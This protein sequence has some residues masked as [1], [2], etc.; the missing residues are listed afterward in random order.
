M[1]KDMIFHC[2]GGQV[3]TGKV[4]YKLS[5]SPVLSFHFPGEGDKGNELSNIWVIS[6]EC[7]AE[8][9]IDG[10]AYSGV[11]GGDV[12]VSYATA[13]MT[14]ISITSDAADAG[15]YFRFRVSTTALKR[16]LQMSYLACS[17]KEEYEIAGKTIVKGFIEILKQ[18]SH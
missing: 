6:R 7:L 18:H 14:E 8:V 16:A 12:V 4:S 13:T 17:R 15:N 11:R 9:V 1:I 2:D 5:E 10:K 3:F